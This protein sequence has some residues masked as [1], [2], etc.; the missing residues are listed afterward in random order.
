MTLKKEASMTNE[1]MILHENKMRMGQRPDPQEAQ[2]GAEHLRT[3]KSQMIDAAQYVRDMSRELA[4]MA[5]AAGLQLVAHCLSMAS[6]EA[7]L[8]ITRSKWEAA[9]EQSGDGHG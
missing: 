2:N 5:G 6:H 9:D 3:E 8:V 1:M 4:V 7:N